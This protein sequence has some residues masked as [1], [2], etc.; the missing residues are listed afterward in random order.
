MVTGRDGAET[1]NTVPGRVSIT[2]SRLVILH[3]P[4]DLEVGQEIC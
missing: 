3:D 1:L 4:A 2:S